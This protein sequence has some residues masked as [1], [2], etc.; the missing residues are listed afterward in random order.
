MKDLGEAKSVMYDSPSMPAENEKSYPSVYLPLSLLGDQKFNKDSEVTLSFKGKIKSI[1]INDY[2]NEFC[3]EL[4]NG[5]ATVD[6]APK[7]SLLNST[8]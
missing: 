8:K 6:E 2:R 3:V 5:E 1:S 4:R 7:V